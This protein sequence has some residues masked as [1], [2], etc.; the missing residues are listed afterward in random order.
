[1]LKTIVF[2]TVFAIF[3]SILTDCAESS[4]IRLVSPM[5]AAARSVIPGW[6]Q[7][8]TRSKIQGVIVFL[9]VGLF[10]AGGVRADA[11]YRDFYNNKYTPAVLTD[12]DQA[13]FY[14]DRSNQYFKLSRF[15]LAAAGGIWLYSALDAYVDAQIYNARQRASVLDI[16]DG[17]LRQLKPGNGLSKATVPKSGYLSSLCFSSE[18]HIEFAFKR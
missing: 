3:L 2:F 6:G 18:K 9:S 11:I 17:S 10:A 8:Y 1:M 14:Y 7:I 15:L 5:G 12:S 4:E 16:D 13:D